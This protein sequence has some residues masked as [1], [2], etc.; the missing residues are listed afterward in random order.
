MNIRDVRPEE[1]EYI[2][3]LLSRCGWTKKI[4]DPEVFAK[5]LK[6]SQIAIVA[7]I[8]GK[9]VGFLRAITD[10]TFNG[11]ISMVAVESELRGKGIG[12]ALVS[13][14]I[15]GNPSISWVLRANRPGVSKFYETLGFQ[16]STA[17]MEKKRAG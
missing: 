3:M 5:A 10:F 8:D 13:K 16:Q 15:D 9:I 17:A 4:E 12:A 11:Y 1:F 6:N 14:V 7:E 2:R